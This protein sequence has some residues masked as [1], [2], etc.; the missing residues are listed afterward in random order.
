M[1]DVPPPPISKKDKKTAKSK[2]A[3]KNEQVDKTTPIP[4][5]T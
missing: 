5:K 3:P 4:K 2:K 1:E